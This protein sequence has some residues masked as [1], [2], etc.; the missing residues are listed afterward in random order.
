MVE[1]SCSMQMIPRESGEKQTNKHVLWKHVVTSD[2]SCLGDPR[3]PHK[4]EDIKT[5]LWE[6]LFWSKIE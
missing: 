5:V 2:S 4:I 1:N 6:V 3:G